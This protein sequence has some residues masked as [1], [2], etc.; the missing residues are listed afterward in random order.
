MGGLLGSVGI[1]SS[2]GAQGLGF[3]ASGANLQQPTTSA[4]ADTAYNQAQQG[5]AG[6]QSF[7][8]ALQGQNGI[9]NQSSVF[10]QLQGVASGTGP[11][12]AQAQLAQ[13]TGANTAN[14]AALMAGQRGAGANTG[15][16]ARQAAQQG[17][18]NQQAAAGQAATLQA[19]QS[20][21]A[22]GQLGGIAGQQVGQQ[23]AA[24][25][26]VTGATQSEQGQLLGAIQGQNTNNVAMQS[27]INTANAGLAN[28]GAQLQ[29][30]NVG[31]LTGG[32]ATTLGLAGGGMVPHYADGTPDATVAQ[33]AQPVAPT[34]PK[35]GALSAMAKSMKGLPAA[36][37]AIDPQAAANASPG[38]AIGMALGAGI[39]ALFGGSS[40]TPGITA[41]GQATPDASQTSY[42][43]Q[44]AAPS[45]MAANTTGIQAGGAA[46]GIQLAKG[47]KVPAM[48]SPG[49]RYLP[50]KAVAEVAKGKSPLKAGEMIPGK[51]K[52]KGD[53][54]KNDVVPKTL[55][56]G[57]IVLPRSVMESKHP[58]WEAHKFV[59]AIM[60]K[61]GQLPP[62]GK[63]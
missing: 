47:G 39:K 49:E 61:K 8:N 11:N 14:Q 26:A 41:T 30:Q 6:Q 24:T 46:G 10:N 7:L 1:G 62:R 51:A 58:H 44:Q 32:V 20:L 29:Q 52:V 2:P 15:L 50:P 9:G 12:P 13:S 38:H 5:I 16:I 54:L 22:L 23:A 34:A 18:A 48:V 57:G 36:G 3:Q 40:P 55:E 59:S 56:E 19:Q 27:N 33:P 37:G 35:T 53:S 63:K 28:T 21:G 17:G 42:T 25:G 60:A 31:G 43:P 4:Q 45:S